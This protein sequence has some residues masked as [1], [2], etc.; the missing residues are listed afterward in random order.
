VTSYLAKATA[1]AKQNAFDT[2]TES[3]IKSYLDSYGIPVPQGSKVEELRAY[4]RKQYTYFKYGTTTP[5][6]T[7]MA[8]LSESVK[9]A[10]DWVA[11]QVGLG[12]DA[13]KKQAG[14]AK[15]KVKDEL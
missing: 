1:A 2:W 14:D 10:W 4:A 11:H 15:A 9:E 5:S 7:I 12:A 8:K 13:A 6:E 3:E